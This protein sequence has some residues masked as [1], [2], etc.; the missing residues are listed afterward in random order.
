MSTQY[1]R[2]S[3]S[4]TY[5]FYA[6]LA[7]FSLSFALSDMT[8]LASYKNSTSASWAWYKKKQPVAPLQT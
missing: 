4:L 1:A 7:Q 8:P 5:L 2:S 3:S 6:Q